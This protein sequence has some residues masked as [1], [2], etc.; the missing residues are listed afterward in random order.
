MIC[1]ESP[2]SNVY[3]G[4][5]RRVTIGGAIRPWSARTMRKLLLVPLILMRTRFVI[6]SAELSVNYVNAMDTVYCES[7]HI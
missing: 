5:I 2:A 6:G 3:T 1:G 4:Y 7:T